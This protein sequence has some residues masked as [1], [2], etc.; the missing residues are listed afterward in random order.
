MNQLFTFQAPKHAKAMLRQGARDLGHTL[1]HR[2]HLMTLGVFVRMQ[3]KC[4]EDSGHE[5]SLCR[6]DPGHGFAPSQPHDSRA[7]RSDLKIRHAHKD[8]GEDLL[9]MLPRVGR[10]GQR[11]RGGDDSN[12]KCQRVAYRQ[13]H[14]FSWA[15]GC[16]HA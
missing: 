7:L 11:A 10:H 16:E 8:G 6:C 2:F 5:C 13:I 1:L 4:Q 12:G 15:S 3:K 14:R 9:H